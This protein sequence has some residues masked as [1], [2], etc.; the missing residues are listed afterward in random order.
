MAPQEA[1]LDGWQLTDRLGKMDIRFTV[2]D[3]VGP[4]GLFLM[5]RGSDDA[6]L[7][8]P[9]DKIYQGSLT[10][11]GMR[12]KLFD[13]ECRLADEISASARWPDLL[14]CSGA[15]PVLPTPAI[16]GELRVL[17]G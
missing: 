16:S 6:L 15:L 11:T 13:A 12:L 2:R 8:M 4:K 9:A 1:R 5:E 14:L 17:R 10:N 7:G 3:V